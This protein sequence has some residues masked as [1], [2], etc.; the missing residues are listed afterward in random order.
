MSELSINNIAGMGMDYE[1]TRIEMAMLRLSLVDVS[2]SSS[3]E[4]SSF[5]SNAQSKFSNQ[6]S[7]SE[8]SNKN[9]TT[10]SISDP[11]NPNADIHGNAY[12]LNIDPTKEMATLVAATRAYEANVKAYNINAQ[13]VRSALELG[14]K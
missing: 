4:A 10:K 8:L 3:A 7:S 5:L 9:I 2:F 1:R 12:Y 14:A 11:T 6:L 13:M